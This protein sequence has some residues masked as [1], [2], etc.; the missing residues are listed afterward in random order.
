[1][2]FRM[3]YADTGATGRRSEADPELV[4]I[5]QALSLY[6]VDRED[7]WAWHGSLSRDEKDQALSGFVEF[8]GDLLAAGAIEEH[9]DRSA[10]AGRS[11]M[12]WYVDAWDD[13]SKRWRKSTQGWHS[14]AEIQESDRKRQARSA[15]R[16]GGAAVVVLIVLW[17]GSVLGSPR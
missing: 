13:R 16:A 11:A 7:L 6:E 14:A 2:E 12:V 3:A 9:D 10:C 4:F 5:A 1:M 15:I 8:V 17:I